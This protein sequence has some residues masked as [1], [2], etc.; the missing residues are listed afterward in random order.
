M[1][2]PKPNIGKPTPQGNVKRMRHSSLKGLQTGQSANN[3]K[4][5]GTYVAHI[6]CS[7]SVTAETAG[8]SCH[9]KG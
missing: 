9:L 2:Q 6:T 7:H 8:G 4:W 3:G 5:E 1:A